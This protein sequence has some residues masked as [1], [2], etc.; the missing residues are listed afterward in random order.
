MSIGGLGST[1]SN[2]SLNFICR[3][4]FFLSFIN[5]QMPSNFIPF[6]E[7]APEYQRFE[8]DRRTQ[9]D[10][11]LTTKFM[12]RQDIIEKITSNPNDISD[13]AAKD[14]KPFFYDVFRSWSH[15]FRDPDTNIR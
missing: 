13:L 2:F 5:W 7:R 8:D 10:I 3:P 4:Y 14:D 15:C 11:G 6:S 12:V 9:R 1:I